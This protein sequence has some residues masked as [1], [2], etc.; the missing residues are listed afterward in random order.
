[1]EDHV[2]QGG[3][4]QM[5]QAFLQRKEIC[6]PCVHINWPDRFIEHGTVQQLYERYGM[7][8][9]AVAG[10]VSEELQN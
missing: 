1:M 9:E 2:Y 10:K 5:V 4:S 6:V 3:F 7:T 8:A